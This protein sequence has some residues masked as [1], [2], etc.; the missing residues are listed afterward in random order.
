ML[1]SILLRC[2]EWKQ[3]KLEAINSASLHCVFAAHKKA[4]FCFQKATPATC[5]DPV[6]PT[7]KK[8]KGK[9]NFGPLRFRLLI[10]QQTRRGWL[11][12]IAERLYSI[13]VTSANL[14]ERIRS[15]VKRQ[16]RRGKECENKTKRPSPKEFA[17]L[18]IFTALRLCLWKRG[19]FQ[20]VMCTEKATYFR[21]READESVGR[22]RQS[23]A[24][25]S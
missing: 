4:A 14:D 16:A 20:L 10:R 7:R 12:F 25:V 22:A 21:W 3:G 23:E 19:Q 1:R 2:P 15:F 9:R 18:S 5:P 11:I 24:G 17:L 13:L 6:S 8:H